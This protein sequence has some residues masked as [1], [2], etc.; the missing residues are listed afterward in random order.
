MRRCPNLSFSGLFD[1]YLFGVHFIAFDSGVRITLSQGY[2]QPA[3][4]F[5]GRE[6]TSSLV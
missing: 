6:F 3:G 5:T 4:K 1:V 2:I